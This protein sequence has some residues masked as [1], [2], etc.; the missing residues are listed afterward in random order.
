M[1]FYIPDPSWW[2]KPA[3]QLKIVLDHMH[4]LYLQRI[5]AHPNAYVH[6]V[7]E[8]HATGIQV[9]AG[10]CKLMNIAIGTNCIKCQMLHVFVI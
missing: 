7:L 10:P 5:C 6:V 4:I 1:Y 8:V 3:M 9:P 2:V